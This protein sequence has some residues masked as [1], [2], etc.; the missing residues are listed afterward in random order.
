MK[1]PVILTP[2]E[3][4]WIVAECPVLPGCISQGKTKEE[5]LYNIKKLPNSGWRKNQPDSKYLSN[6]L[7][8]LDR[9]TLRALSEN[10]V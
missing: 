4:G 5:A 8:T 1:F 6:I 10:P 2:G 3:D 9:G 7:K